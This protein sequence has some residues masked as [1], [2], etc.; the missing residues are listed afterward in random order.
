[1]ELTISIAVA[2]A[3]LIGLAVGHSWL[4]ERRLLVPMFASAS[5]QELAVEPTFARP[6]LRLAWH[7]TSLGWLTF[8]YLLFSGTCDPMPVAALLGV[9]GIATYAA[10][11]GRHFAWALFLIGALAAASASWDAA[12]WPRVA[13]VSGTL[14]L[15]AI[16]ILHV[17]WALGLRWGMGSVIPEQLGRPLFAPPRAITLLVAA[18]LFVA[19]WLLL[20]L[21]DWLPAPLPRAW[22]T[23]AGALAAAVFGLRALGD[24]RFVGL[25]KR[26]RDTRFARLDDAL[27]TPLC[28]ALCAA[29]LLQF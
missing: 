25:F 15:S 8:A 28:I 6:T 4:G 2:G 24:G 13:A 20:V 9:S 1:M 29:I 14:A 21:G 16:G 5:F 26:E 27:F 23:V 18:A 12:L 10:T 7:F 3:S 11:G 22:I 17:A 19:A